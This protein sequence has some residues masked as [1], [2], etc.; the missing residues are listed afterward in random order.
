MELGRPGGELGGVKTG[1]VRHRME[2]IKIAGYTFS[3]REKT[4]VLQSGI[5]YM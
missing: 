4:S 3:S 2:L 1:A 5:A